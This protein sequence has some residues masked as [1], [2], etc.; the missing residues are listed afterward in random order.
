[1][2]SSASWFW[3]FLACVAI[4]FEIGISA[5]KNA[6]LLGDPTKLKQQL[7]ALCAKS[8][9]N[10]FFPGGVGG[11]ATRMLW[12]S[13][14][15]IGIGRAALTIFMDRLSGFCTQLFVTLISLAVLLGAFNQV[16]LKM[17][18]LGVALLVLIIFVF[19]L[20]LIRLLPIVGQKSQQWLHLEIAD[21]GFEAKQFVQAWKKFPTQPSYLLI[22]GLFSLASQAAMMGLVYSAGHA[23]GTDI[24][25]WQTSPIM[26]LSAL[27]TLAPLTIGN[28]GITEGVYALGFVFFGFPPENG[29]A[30]SLLLRA[31]LLPLSLVGGW[32]FIRK[33]G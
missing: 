4:G 24:T 3:I 25:L 22:L 5:W 13:R 6:W 27:S 14:E 29:A 16:T 10:Q 33:L 9:V 23:F 20:L 18:G 15:D 1:M 11:E 7:M 12:I 17:A 31:I 26:L 21:K 30:V 28:V 32:L 19:P 8:F 2:I